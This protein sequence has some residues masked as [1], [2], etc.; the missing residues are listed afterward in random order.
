MD[1]KETGELL[2][3]TIVRLGISNLSLGWEEPTRPFQALPTYN[4]GPSSMSSGLI[5]T[6]PIPI[7]STKTHAAAPLRRSAI[8]KHLRP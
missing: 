7:G 6:Q 1:T 4:N 2:G 8:F 5:P 3:Y